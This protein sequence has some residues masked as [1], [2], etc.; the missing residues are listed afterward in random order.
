MTKIF[1]IIV[2]IILLVLPLGLLTIGQFG[3]LTG[4][5]PTDLGL[6]DGMLKPPVLASSNVVSSYAALQPHT[7]YHVIDPIAYT[8]K[9][10]TAFR[11]LAALVGKME[12]A[13][14]ITSDPGYLYAQ[15]QSRLLKFTDDVEFVLDASTSVIQMRSASRLGIKDLGANRTRLEEIRTLFNS[16]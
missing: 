9:G 16:Q 10:D 11:K 4:K 14:V 8:G 12:G 6:H 13:T 15:F 3:L 1:G 5:Q 7:A 2:L